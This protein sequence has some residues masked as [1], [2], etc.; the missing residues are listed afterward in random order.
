MFNC[1]RFDLFLLLCTFC[2]PKIESCL[3]ILQNPNPS[4][5]SRGDTLWREGEE[6]VVVSSDPIRQEILVKTNDSEPVL[7][8]A[9]LLSTVPPST[10]LPTPRCKKSR[11]SEKGILQAANLPVTS[12]GSSNLPVTPSDL[13]VR[14]PD[15]PTTTS[16]TE[17]D[18]DFLVYVLDNGTVLRIGTLIKLCHNQGPVLVS[19][20]FRRACGRIFVSCFMCRCDYTKVVSVLRDFQFTADSSYIECCGMSQ[21][22]LSSVSS[23]LSSVLEEAHVRVCACQERNLGL[24]SYVRDLRRHS[25]GALMRQAVHSGISVNATRPVAPVTL[26]AFDSLHDAA[27]FGLNATNKFKVSFSLSGG[28]QGLDFVMGKGW[29]VKPLKASVVDSHFKYVR[30]LSLYV[31]KHFFLKFSFSYSE[32]PFALQEVEDYREKC[33]S[34]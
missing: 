34:L 3:L 6:V 21:F 15:P 30:K 28:F 27:I 24:I 16:N 29:D 23:H 33:R 32:A 10:K 14:A 4:K 9:S 20:I 18:L 26:G 22:S 13:P 31:D 8:D 25:L 17:T 7:L 1:L 19:R 2:L 12:V 11:K 5:L